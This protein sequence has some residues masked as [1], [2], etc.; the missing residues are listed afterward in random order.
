MRIKLTDRT[1]DSTS[2]IG[3]YVIAADGGAIYVTDKGQPFRLQALPAHPGASTRERPAAVSKRTF[4][5][6][7]SGGVRAPVR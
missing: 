6:K 5:E 4:F 3:R 7:H 1:L 2:Q